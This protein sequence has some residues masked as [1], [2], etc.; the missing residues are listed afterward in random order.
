MAS[1]SCAVLSNG[2]VGAEKQAVALAEAVG[3]PFSRILARP[4]AVARRLPTR[5]A[6]AAGRW[7][8]TGLP[9]GLDPPSLAISCGRASIPA[10]VALRAASAGRTLTVHVQRPPCDPALFDLVVAPAHD[11][12]RSETPPPNALLTDG[13]L[14]AIDQPLLRRA[15]SEWR[16]ALAPLPPPRVALLFGGTVSRRWWHRPLAPPVSAGVERVPRASPS[17]ARHNTTLPAACHRLGARPRSLGGGGAGGDL[18]R[19]R[20]R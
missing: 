11:Y 8:D 3:L 14:H 6:L 17:F 13:S 18:R 9:G 19:R 7:L 20:R 15:A 4:D 10:S 5:L 2:V 16:D 12:A 1:R